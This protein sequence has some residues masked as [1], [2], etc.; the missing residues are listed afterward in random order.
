MED[1]AEA[2]GILK[3]SLY[4][5]I[6]SK[7][8]LLFEIVQAAHEEA[9]HR[10]KSTESLNA[11]PL[12]KLRAFVV[13]HLVDN[14]VNLERSAVFFNDFN[15]LHDEHRQ[16]VIRERDVY[17]RFVRD[18]IREGQRDRTICPDIDPKLGA[19][20]V[21]GM[22]NW[23]YG[24]F[25]PTGELS[26]REIANAYGDLAVAGLACDP[27]THTPGHRRDPVSCTTAVP[28]SSEPT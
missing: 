2:V 17:E 11:A 23:L 7:E 18:L 3:G 10:L 5:Y 16:L 13:V 8:E 1:L 28:V 19:I 6:A 15:S 24:W 14:L 22:M 25:E 26:A 4:Y 20:M 9:I 27:E 21:L 12:Q